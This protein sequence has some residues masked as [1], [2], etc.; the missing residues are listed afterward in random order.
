M[1]GSRGARGEDR[2]FPM[3]FARARPC[4]FARYQNVGTEGL[5][6]LGA[7]E[8]QPSCKRL[9]VPVPGGGGQSQRRTEVGKYCSSPLVLGQLLAILETTPHGA[10][11]M[12]D[13]KSPSFSRIFC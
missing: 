6:I 9:A 2:F 11:G 8:A 7:D 3:R 10:F 1:A 12:I 13:Q 5:W 4:R